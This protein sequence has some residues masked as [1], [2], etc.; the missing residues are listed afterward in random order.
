MNKAVAAGIGIG[1]VLIAIAALMMNQTDESNT[2]VDL[3]EDVEI[4]AEESKS[5]DTLVVIE[6]GVSV[7]DKPP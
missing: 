2:Q 4:A 5:S 1:I 3:S 7:G 6:E